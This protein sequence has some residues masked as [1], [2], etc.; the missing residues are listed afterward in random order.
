MRAQTVRQ[1]PE[2]QPTTS[3]TMIIGHKRQR[4]EAS[5]PKPQQQAPAAAAPKTE[6]CLC[7]S[8]QCVTLCSHCVNTY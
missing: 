6:I 7:G 5:K 3:S 4:E 2:T 8:G 1:F